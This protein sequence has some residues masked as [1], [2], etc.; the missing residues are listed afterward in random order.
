[1]RNKQQLAAGVVVRPLLVHLSGFLR[2]LE[3]MEND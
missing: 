1:M 3:N 2:V